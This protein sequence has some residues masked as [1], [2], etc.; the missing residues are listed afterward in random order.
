MNNW[1]IGLLSWNIK[2]VESKVFFVLSG[3]SDI[4]N[5]FKPVVLNLFGVTVH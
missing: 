5:S 2:K 4:Y 1:I 3:E